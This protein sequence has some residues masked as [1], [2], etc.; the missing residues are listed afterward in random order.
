MSARAGNWRTPRTG[1]GGWRLAARPGAALRRE[2]SS[3][4]LSGPGEAGE[5]RGQLAAAGMKAEELEG[6]AGS[7]GQGGRPGRSGARGQGEEI[8]DDP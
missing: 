4:G 2:R 3:Q 1:R 7:G 6:I 8:E 5:L